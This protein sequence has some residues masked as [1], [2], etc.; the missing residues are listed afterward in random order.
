MPFDEAVDMARQMNT[1]AVECL[2]LAQGFLNKGMPDRWGQ[3]VTLGMTS[4]EKAWDL[5]DM[6]MEHVMSQLGAVGELVAAIRDGGRLD[7][8]AVTSLM[9][10]QDGFVKSR[11]LVLGLIRLGLYDPDDDDVLARVTGNGVGQATRNGAPAKLS[12]VVDNPPDQ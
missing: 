4:M 6:I 12:L 2:T 8:G 3:A 7:T 5:Q 1:Q 11:D 9:A 10:A